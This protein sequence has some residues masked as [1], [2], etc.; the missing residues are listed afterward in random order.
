[1][2]H[3]PNDES[4]GPQQWGL[5]LAVVVAFVLRLFHLGHQS[6]WTDEVFTWMTSSPHAPITLGEVL[7]NFHGPLVSLF[8]HGWIRIFGD[9]EWSLRLPMALAS[10]ALVPVIAALA[11]AAGGPRA[12]LPAAWFAAI[13][14]FFIW[15][16]QESRNYAFAMLFAAL[17]V[18]ATLRYRQTGRRNEIVLLAVAAALGALSN[19]NTMLLLP[20]L[21]G[22]LVLFPPDSVRGRA[23]GRWRV[24][25]TV[26]AV[27]TIA[28][29]P[30]ILA[31]FDVIEFHRLIPGRAELPSETPLRGATTFRWIA[32][33]YALY[34]YSVGFTLGPGL[35]ELRTGATWEAIAPHLPVIAAAAFAF[36][37]LA[38]AGARRL[39]ERRFA[40]LVILTAI[41][42]PLAIVSY[43]ALMNF[44]PFNPRYASVGAPAWIV[45]L[46]V[47]W[48][49]LAP[50]WRRVARIWIFGLWAIA[51][52]HHYFDAR[53]AKDDFRSV[54]RVLARETRTGEQIVAAGDRTP[55]FYYWHGREPAVTTYWL[56]WAT[57]PARAEKFES[58]RSPEGTTWVTVARPWDLDPEGR[59]EAWLAD[60]L[61]AEADTFTGVRLYRVPPAHPGR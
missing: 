59:F 31:R 3:E 4:P 46:A 52:A 41:V 23:F 5:W 21:L 20:A 53:Y 36:G 40:L 30:W 15:Y 9:S 37:A 48:S 47:G 54:A 39:A 25:L 1:M 44:K 58:R 34:V 43:F 38:W 60:S 49:A 27:V 13:S 61:G 11:R 16:G 26:A 14:P 28:L 57:G 12:V 56:G 10:T 29:L 35:R 2:S 32:I 22:W 55:L 8:L 50:V 7:E 17:Q 6:L 45:L 42:L 19:L 33:P 24:P 18:G 51:L